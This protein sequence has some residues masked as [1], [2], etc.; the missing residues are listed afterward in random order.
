MPESLEVTRSEA[1]KF[2]VDGL[3]ISGRRFRREEI[4]DVKIVVERLQFIQCQNVV[5]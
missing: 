3:V 4:E 5:L 2:H 1:Q